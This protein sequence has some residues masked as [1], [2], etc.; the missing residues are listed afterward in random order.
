MISELKPFITA[1]VFS[2]ALLFFG[3]VFGLLL[4]SKKPKLG[5]LVSFFSIALV[6]ILSTPACSVWLS[7]NLPKQYEP[8]SVQQLKDHGVQAIVVLGGGVDTGQPDGIQQLPPTALDRLRHGIELSRKTGIPVLVTGGKGW[9]AQYGSEN[10]AAI[11]KRV[12]REVF[13]YQIQWT[14]SESRDTQENA[15]NSKQLLAQQGINKIALV[16]HS[17]HMPRS[18]KAFQK[19]GFEVTPAPMGFVAN[20]EVDLISLSPHGGALMSTTAILKELVAQA[21][22][23][24]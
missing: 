13:Q 21:V 3:I 24:Q 11:A 1:L 5:K 10:E 12:A 20:K 15:F 9:G 16:T 22:Q 17:W 14:E 23:G 4:S 19:V 7:H 18:L 6:W 2:P 8:T